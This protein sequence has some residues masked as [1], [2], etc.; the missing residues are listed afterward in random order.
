L[1]AEANE[2]KGQDLNEA[3]S[4]HQRITGLMREMALYHSVLR[5]KI[6]EEYKSAKAKGTNADE[7]AAINKNYLNRLEDLQENMA[8]FEHNFCTQF[9]VKRDLGDRAKQMFKQMKVKEAQQKH[10]VAQESLYEL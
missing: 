8:D 3:T 10:D 2:L 1:L 7:I 4:F 6:E 5:K 9:K